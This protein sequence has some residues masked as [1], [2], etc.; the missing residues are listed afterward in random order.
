MTTPTTPATAGAAPRIA[1]GLTLDAINRAIGS[2]PLVERRG[3]VTAVSG[4]A[5]R[6]KVPDIQLGEACRISRPGA[7]DLVCEVIAFDRDEVVMMPMGHMD[8]VA[9]NAP[10]LALGADLR[11]PCGPIV[12]GRIL[13]GLGRPIDAGPSLEGAPTTPMMRPPPNPLKRRRITEPLSTGVTAIDT[14]LTVGRGQRMGIFA[15]AGVGKSTLLSSIAK[16]AD[17][18][19]VVLALIGERGREV[20]GFIEDDLGPEGLAKSTVVVSTSDEPAMLRLKAAYTATAIAETARAEGKN[21]VLM[22][23]S[24][25][26]FARALREI[27]LAANEPPGRQGFPPSVFATLPRLLERAGNDDAGTMTA[28]YTVLVSG[29]DVNEP[30]A[31]EARSLLDGHVTLSRRLAGRGHYPAIDLTDSKSRVMH[32]IVSREHAAAAAR[33]VQV[34][35]SYEQNYDKIALGLYE[36]PAGSAELDP[37]PWYPKVARFVTQDRHARARPLDQS[38]S[39]LRALFAPRG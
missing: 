23:D 13:D 32:E 6:A 10:V 39:E 29:D 4:P 17:A 7:P 1:A 15:A 16:N 11:V 26:R 37:V 33:A 22:M 31:D 19:V 21:V 30:V 27:G 36:H 35:A 34:V 2:A 5:I 14:L 38:V 20:L 12:R 8:K 28:F 24:V 9:I 25:T 18:D 3:R